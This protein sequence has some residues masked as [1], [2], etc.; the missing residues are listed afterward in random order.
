MLPALAIFRYTLKLVLFPPC[1]KNRDFL[2]NYTQTKYWLCSEDGA[3]HGTPKPTISLQL[4]VASFWLPY[5]GTRRNG[6]DSLKSMHHR[7]SLSGGNLVF[8]LI[9]WF[10]VYVMALANC[11][12]SEMVNFIVLP[13][14][15]IFP[16]FNIFNDVI[17]SVVPAAFESYVTEWHNEYKQQ[18]LV[19][20]FFHL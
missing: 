1:S 18:S 15:L 20:P 3:F 6:E 2:G 14:F 11:C 17:Q 4:T 19:P 9:G 12:S 8:L 13:F 16:A 10:S 5:H 7:C